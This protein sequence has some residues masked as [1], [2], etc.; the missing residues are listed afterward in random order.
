MRYI[1][2]T[3]LVVILSILPHYVFA[4]NGNQLDT[5][6]I[7][8]KIIANTNG[9]IQVYPK[10]F[11][12]TIDGLVATSS[13]S[14]IVKILSIEKDVSH[15][16][17]NINISALNTGQ[18]TINMAASGFVPLQLPVTVYPDSKG[19]SSLLIKATPTTFSTSGPNTGYISVETVNSDGVPSPVSADTTIQLSVSDGNVATLTED[20]MTI[21]QGSYFATETFEVKNPG[22]VKI[23][24]SAPSM[25]PVS[26]SITINNYVAPYTVQ[27]YAYPPIVNVNKDAT[28]YI[29][30]QLH[31]A[32]GNPVIAKN[33]IPVSVQIVNL[34]DSAS[35][36]TSGQSPFV[37][38]N[39]ALVIPKGSY[40]GYIP[41]EFTAG[42]NATYNVDI[43][44]KDYAVSMIPATTTVTTSTTASTGTT[45]PG[46]STTATGTST[47]T[48]TTSASGATTTTR[49]TSTT[50]T[51]TN[52]ATTATGTTTGSSTS[53]SICSLS[54]ILTSASQVQIAAVSQ[55]YFL[56]DKTPCFYPLPILTTGNRELIGVLALKDSSGYPA[57]AKSVLSFQIDSSDTST[58]SLPDVKMSY[59]E[60]SALVFAQVS[61]SANP[62]TLNVVSSSPQQVMPVIASPSQTTSGLVA[63][64]LLQTVLPNAKFPLAIYAVNNGALGSFTHDFTALISPQNT[65]SPIQL[66][67]TKN[68]PIFLTNETLLQG[69]QQNIAITA[70][71]YSYSFTVTGALPSKPGNIMLGYP[72]Q[73]FSNSNILFS[74]ELLDDKQ[75][76]LL[77]DK[78]TYIKL[79]SS[80]P[81]V[82]VVPDSVP[83]KEGSYYTTFDAQSKEAGTAEI[84][85]LADG[86]PLSKFDITT[87]SYTPVVSIDSTDHADN[88]TPLTATVTATHNNSPLAGLNVDWAITGG[89]IKNKDSV[90]DQDG[91]ATVSLITN[92]PNK[93]SIQASVGGGLY[94]TVTVTKQISINPPLVAASPAK[95]S[96]QDNTQPTGFT[97]M[98]INPLFLIIPVAAGAAILVLKKKEM[99][100][101]ISEKIG[102]E[103]KI[104]GIK[105][106]FT[107]MRE[108]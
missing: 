69:G 61:N 65:I 62:V 43:S 46:S 25:Q 30:V 26:T 13:D 11:S 54:P 50:G 79:V 33:N 108:K 105:E 93:V 73:I 38:V 90:T 59:G 100:E 20:Q 21:K 57:L 36:N 17:F 83:V 88:N 39:N 24:A 31:D 37:Q 15:D 75:L 63:D 55:N 41:I 9:T 84:A 44:A 98:G 96:T 10:N 34:A 78:D 53:A 86:I 2:V 76:P 72:D 7:P 23:Y 74:I 6:L 67:I 51:T 49:S 66:S 104:S 89:T 29:I 58:V 101:G 92:D 42:L 16:V 12:N 1:A 56:D 99:L 95:Q 107:E 102:L 47:S 81:S 82:L 32:A 3:L 40:W 70:P 48:S 97:V 91:K 19:A 52:G 5:T 14:S 68:D 22:S 87:V 71:N 60:Q 77:A 85:V 103:E 106:R 94:Q 27:V 35:V 80:N 8:N 4:D 45:A 28:T 64:S 18:A